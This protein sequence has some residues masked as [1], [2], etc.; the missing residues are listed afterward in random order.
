VSSPVSEEPSLL[1]LL[2]VLLVLLVEAEL[3]WAV[4]VANAAS[5]FAGPRL[6]R[7]L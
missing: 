1:L 5:P 2:L 3:E 4:P 7:S 6:D